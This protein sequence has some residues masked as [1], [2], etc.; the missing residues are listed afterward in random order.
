MFR[1]YLKIAWRNLLKHKGYT[2]INISGLAVGVCCFLLL[3]MFVKSEFSY[4]RFHANADRIY[5]VWQDEN[6]GPKENFVNTVTPVSMV[7]VLQGN[8]PEIEAA[9]RVYAFNG[10]VKRNG[11]EFNESL[12]AVDPSFFKIFDFELLAGNPESPFTDVNSIILSETAAEKYF[13]LEN[14]LGKILELQMEEETVLFE[15]SGLIADP[16]EES[17]IQFDLL[18][19]LENEARF[20]GEQAR[21]SWFNVSVESYLL[22]KPEQ[23]AADLEAKFPTV[24]KQYLGDDFQEGTFLLHL[25][26]LKAIHLNNALPAGIEPISN[27]MY[28][29]VLATIGLMILLLAC[30]NF[31]T[32]A[33]GRS[34]SRAT[35]VGVRKALGAF[36][37]QIR[38]QFWGEAILT[39]LLSVLFGI[40]L[41]VLLMDTFNGLTGKSLVISF[42]FGFLLA[43]LG[44]IG[45]ISL[46]AGIYPSFVLSNFSPIEVLVRKKVKGASMGLFGKALVVA[47]FV[48]AMVMII[49]TL[50]IGRQIDF[51]VSKDLGYQKEAIV[52]VPTHQ[53]GEAADKMAKLYIDALKKQPQVADVTVSIFSFIEGSWFDMGFTDSKNNYKEFAFNGV[54]A[55]FLK[56]HNIEIVDGRDFEEGNASDALNGVLVN[57]TF[58]R[59][60]GLDNAIGTPFEKFGVTI[61]GVVEDFN[62]QSLNY[63]ISPLLL[64]MNP[65]PIFRN[66]ENVGAQYFSQPRISVRVNGND[67]QSNI[68]LLKKTWEQINPSQEFD[69]AFLDE[70]L[71]ARYQNEQRSKT[72]V[73]IASIL[74]I[75][76]ACMGLFG[77]A[78]LSVAR[79]TA[80]I[81]I[82]KVMGASMP[83]IV[84]M[85]AKDF[86]KLVLIASLVACPLAWWAMK[87]WLQDFA[88]SA[89]LPWWV[90]MVSAI[91]VVG[92]TLFT[93]GFQSVRASLANPVDSLRME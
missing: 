46:V 92:L 21:R 19:S 52:V 63:P 61:L 11:I 84:V 73:N 16:P 24:V 83:D 44:L 20:F 49:S 15:V 3:S 74:S 89:D 41:S 48:T 1:N 18:V 13:G 64:S 91:G 90:F 88:Y 70:S 8:Y 45:F 72:I 30:I 6:Y 93:V 14:P 51:L 23:T 77:L 65:E 9:T 76:I 54:D 4:D 36:R 53:S 39:T 56:T 38:Y 87:L 69:F 67:L 82:R 79:R 7:P 37:S 75:F 10:L 22:L 27:P 5:R 28:S 17:S 58:V 35:E 55:H 29:Y 42:D 25:Q 78:T 31:V 68:G 32:L 80:E 50:V 47:Q 40:F 81:G 33:V 57:E 62:F 59:E 86:V 34:F 26:P 12:R 66:V 71:A 2:A 85:I 60:F 43:T